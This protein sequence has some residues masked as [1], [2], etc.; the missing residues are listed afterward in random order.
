MTDDL[1][2]Q[3]MIAITVF[4]TA[5]LFASSI[6]IT[7]LCMNYLENYSETYVWAVTEVNSKSMVSA[8]AE[9]E[10]YPMSGSLVYKLLNNAGLTFES[11][12]EFDI[13]GNLVRQISITDTDYSELKV[14]DFVTEF[15]KSFNCKKLYK[16]IAEFKYGSNLYS[17]ELWEVDSYE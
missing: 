17:I 4:L 7:V 5:A 15:T 9:S 2:M 8:F 11:I 12:K 13:D 1:G 14:I 10:R 16:G 6:G 3:Q